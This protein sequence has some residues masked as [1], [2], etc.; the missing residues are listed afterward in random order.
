MNAF[1]I[2][3][4]VGNK[5]QFYDVTNPAV[6]GGQLRWQE[7][8]VYAL[9]DSKNPEMV[10]T[11][12]L[13]ASQS[14]INRMGTLS[15]SEDGTLEG[16]VRELLSGNFASMW[17]ER[18]RYTNDE[19]REE[20]LNE[21]LKQ[22]FADFTASGTKFTASPDASKPVSIVYHIVVRNFA[23]RTGKRLFVQPDYFSAGV[24]SRF[25]ESTRYNHIYFEFP[26]SEVDNIRLKVP[27]GFEL[28][29]ADAPSGV[30]MPPTCV[31]AV[32][33]AMDKTNNQLIY[34]RH[35]TFGDK[36]MLMFD[37]KVYPALKKVFDTIHEADNHM[38]TLKTTETASA[39]Q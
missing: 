20:R 10:Q 12:M 39:N 13:S 15:I 30:N 25:S 32:H 28:D 3:V 8:G 1:D 18:N 19:Q 7:Q 37:Q 14:A 2:A 22:R 31:Y 16:K 33:I 34:D 11:P 4:N 38:L 29:H 23:Q 17:R 35:L 6:P 26:W 24:G 21:E 9:I 5:W 27:V 36:Q